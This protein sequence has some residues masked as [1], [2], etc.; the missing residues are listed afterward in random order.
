MDGVKE[1]KAIL[2]TLVGNS[3]KAANEKKEEKAENEDKRKLIDEIGGILKGKVDEEIWRTVVGKLEKVAY[4]PSETD[5]ADNE[6]EEKEEAKNKAKCKNEEEEEKEE[7]EVEYKDFKKEIEK[8][9][10]EEAKNKKAK[11]SLEANRKIFFEGK[12]ENKSKFMSQKDGINL[13][14]ELY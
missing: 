2:E 4:E 14:K 10:E 11:N 5:K 7:K 6:E 1:I 3:F 9:A 13:G 8:E 12:T